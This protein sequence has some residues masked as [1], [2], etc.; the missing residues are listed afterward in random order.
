MPSSLRTRNFNIDRYLNR[1]VPPSPLHNMPY[2]IAHFLGYRKTPPKDVGNILGAIFA[3]IGA[4]VGL[5]AIAGLF[6]Y[7]SINNLNGP[8]LIASFGASAILEYNT[9]ASPL[10]QPRNTLLGHALSATIGVGITKLFALSSLSHSFSNSL[11][12][13]PAALA[14]ALSS[15][16]M[17][18][19]NTV[20]PPGG[21]SAV[22]AATLP[23]IVDMGWAFVG[24]V[25]LG[26][27][28]M[29]AVG[30]VTNNLM[31][32]FPVYWWT[33]DDLRGEKGKERDVEKAE[34]EGAKVTVTRDGMQVPDWLV[35]DVEEMVL[36]ERFGERLRRG[37]GVVDGARRASGASSAQCTVVSS[38]E[39]GGSW[40][41]AESS[42]EDRGLR[43]KEEV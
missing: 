25:T 5:L 36:L 19:T 27:A 15:A 24:L 4:F 38:K 30:L 43:G 14:C 16:A 31:R 29:L 7:T 3:F 37:K 2:P 42:S 18:L 20:H 13:V 26:S 9:L 35:L 34:E 11:A 28:V 10:A 1:L 33:P 22:L 8:V 40:G 39:D 23:E 21:A 6:N 41:L 12:F 17:L 32:R